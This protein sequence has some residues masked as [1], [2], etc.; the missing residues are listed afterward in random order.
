MMQTVSDEELLRTA[1]IRVQESGISGRG[2]FAGREFGR[3][4]ALM[5]ISGEAID[6]V[7]A[8]RRER[9]EAN[10]YIYW[11]HGR[12]FIDAAQTPK[13]R[14]LNHACMPNCKTAPRDETT[15][16]LLALREIAAGEELTMDYDYPEIYAVCRKYNPGCLGA[17]C[18]RAGTSG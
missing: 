12:S 15:L 17:A 8:V 1:D 10:W 11:N 14:F 6:E 5:I 18:P 2:L 3:D 4:E 7:D 13:G 16:Y 9:D